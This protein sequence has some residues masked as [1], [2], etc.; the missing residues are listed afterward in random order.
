VA[1][2]SAVESAGLEPVLDTVL[3][4]IENYSFRISTGQLNRIIGDAVFARPYT[5]K[6]KA[7][8]VYY[9]TQVATRPPTF[10]LFVNDPDILHFSYLRYLMN[11]IREAY[12]LKGTPIRLHVRSSH[13]REEK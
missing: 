1:F 2:T 9:S 12:P 6:G 4:A 7:L 8:K 10:T 11:K 3:Q 13:K 5:T